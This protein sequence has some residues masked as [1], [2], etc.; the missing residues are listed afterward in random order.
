[1][2]AAQNFKPE[3]ATQFSTYATKC[4][5]AALIQS[6]RRKTRDKRNANVF[7]L[8]EFTNP[9]AKIE[10]DFGFVLSWFKDHPDDSAADKRNKRIL[11]DHYFSGMT[12]Q[13]IADQ[14][15]TRYGHSRPVSKMAAKQFGD[16][17]IALIRKRFNLDEFSKVDEL[18]SIA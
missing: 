4:I 8:D 7:A 17:A 2:L 14:M 1:V 5:R 16:Q 10:E 3:M 11:Y 13:E 15:D 18:I 12:W 6:W 9:S